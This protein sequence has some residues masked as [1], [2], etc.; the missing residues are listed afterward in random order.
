MSNGSSSS[1]LP[2]TIATF[3]AGAIFGLALGLFLAYVALPANLVLNDA[4]PLFLRVN[5]TGATVEYQNLFVA[6]VANRYF[7]GVQGG[8]EPA[9]FTEALN[10]LGV[11]SGD[12]TPA[13]ALAMSSAGQLAAEQENLR[14]GAN[15]DAGYFTLADQNSMKLLSDRLVT[16]QGQPAVVPESVIQDRRNALLIG[17]ISL[18]LLGTFLVGALVVLGSRMAGASTTTTTATAAAA[19]APID[20]GAS[21]TYVRPATVDELPEVLIDVK[22]TPPPTEP[23]INVGPATVAAMAGAVS[24]QQHAASPVPGESL[25]A[26]YTTSFSH[27]EDDYDEG[28]QISSSSGDLIGECGASIAERYGLDRPAKVVAL[29]MWVFDKNDFQSTKSVLMTPF[30][31]RDDQIRHKLASRGDAVQARLGMFEVMTSTLRVEVE[32]RNLTLEPIGSD[33]DGYFE[34]VDLE[35]RV[36]RRPL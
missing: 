34:R 9:A 28:F 19:A 21:V 29:G 3:I 20:N 26:T 10:S 14:D 22:T 17:L 33:P 31:F 8:T 35:F 15:P 27:G 36:F 1:R 13:E 4:P 12:A 24:L 5:P 23:G 32:V 2:F 18:A 25:I 7:Q 16:I 30:A 6:R 11:S